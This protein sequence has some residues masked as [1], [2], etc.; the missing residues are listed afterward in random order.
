[1]TAPNE[2]LPEETAGQDPAAAPPPGLVRHW[3]MA[4][5]VAAGATWV[6]MTGGRTNATWRV[7]APTSSPT[8]PSGAPSTPP[9]TPPSGPP[10]G[11]PLDPLSAPVPEHRTAPQPSLVCKLYRPG[12]DTPLFANDP[13]AEAAALAAL[14]GTGL[15]PRLV[16]ASR[17][18]AGGSL[19]YSHVAG[20][21]WRNGDDPAAVARALSRL[22]A[23][24]LPAD[25]PRLPVGAAA[26]S[27]QA[28]EMLDG[29]GA[30]GATLAARLPAGTVGMPAPA[31]VFIHGDATAGNVLVGPDGITFIDW[32]CP[33]A[34]D[35]CEDLATFLSPAMQALSGNAPLTPE[36]EDAFLSAYGDA[37]TVARFRAL[38]PFYHGR[39]AAYCQW[40]AARGDAGY[41]A[42]AE[43]EIAR[44][45]SGQAPTPPPA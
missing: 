13:A 17:T 30:A 42:A 41:G 19:V 7:D 5:V 32:Q 23:A 25:L 18:P 24:P 29:L 39:M 2:T 4:G 14:S 31:R 11:P 6:P 20:R 33:A 26:V 44:I 37:E 34:G 45:R 22:H 28:H 43:L 27:A 35:P 16:A 36:A 38:A 1:M 12:G 10:S 21:P 8:P 9:S 40:R 3:Q 15:A